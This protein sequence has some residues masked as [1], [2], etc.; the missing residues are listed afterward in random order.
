M[1]GNPIPGLTTRDFQLSEDGRR[2][3]IDLCARMGEP[4]SGPSTAL[5]LALLVDTSD[6]MLETLRRSQEAAVRFLTTLPSARELLVVLFDQ[7]QRVERFDRDHPEALFD[8][9]K[10]VPDGGNTALRDAITSTLRT[11]HSST[12]RSALVLLTD[13]LDTVSATT[14]QALERSVQSNAVVIYSSGIPSGVWTKT[15]RLMRPSSRSAVLPR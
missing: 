7:Q 10:A 13:G 2:Q 8:R 4:G 3:Q 11:I 9:L 15:E 12:G 1:T 6:S 14:P 5:D